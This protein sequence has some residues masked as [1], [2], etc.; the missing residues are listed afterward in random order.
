[1]Q[2]FHMG[3][4]LEIFR[5]AA[6]ISGNNI[7]ISIINFAAFLVMLNALGTYGFG[8]LT[9]ALSVL[10]VATFF[11]ELGFG[12]VIV[13]DVSKELHQN[14]MEQA[15]GLFLGYIFFVL[16]STTL[17]AG[18]LFFF[19]GHVSAYFGKDLVL[20][21]QLIAALVFLS[22]A[23]TVVSSAF[24]IVADFGKYASFLFADA[25]SKLAL[26]Y[27][28]V[29]FI[30]GTV[31]A[32]LQA[33][34]ASGIL[35]I[36]VFL[37]FIPK[38]IAEITRMRSNP[39]LFFEMAKR[40]GKWVAVFSQLRSI[41]SNIAPWIVEFFLGVN[42][43]GIY[44][45]LTKVQVLIIRVFEP[46]ETIFYPLV[47]RFGNFNDSRKIVFRATK[48]ILFVSLPFI[49]AAVIFSEYILSVVLGQGFEKYAAVFMVLLLTVVIFILNMPMKPLFFNL[50]AQKSLTVI[51]AVLLAST[52]ALGSVLAFYFGLIGMAANNVST[53][54]IDLSLKNRFMKKV[55]GEKYS[56]REMLFLDKADID[57][58]K[59][60][61]SDPK[62]ALAA[63]KRDAE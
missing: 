56:I 50:K 25:L 14:N 18:M 35:T 28:F 9:L 4:L 57:L 63:F 13:S 31:E 22:G 17:L 38:E 47:S 1:M 54:F 44:G 26:V 12:R 51:S 7:L 3:A 39:W 33:F 11:I 20:I 62:V 58:A 15:S 43:V 40:H 27:L 30:S 55:S 42:S 52:L 32:V 61:F 19:A 59:K 6:I 16:F 23:K 46:L 5:Y 10:S 29:T 8:L 45:A 36:A 53:A 49:I 24:H 48:Y 21:I 2:A 60:I 41:E 34:I 37:F